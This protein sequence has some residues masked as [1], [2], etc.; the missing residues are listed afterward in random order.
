MGLRDALQNPQLPGH[1][2]YRPWMPKRGRG[3]K[4]WA[5]HLGP[6]EPSISKHKKRLAKLAAARADAA[7]DEGK[8]T[9]W[10]HGRG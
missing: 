4:Y 3:F 9:G 1:K 2:T 10:H 5:A 7:E 8:G 6:N